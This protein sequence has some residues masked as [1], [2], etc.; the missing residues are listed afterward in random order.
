MTHDTQAIQRRQAHEATRNTPVADATT[1]VGGRLGTL[2]ETASQ[3][4]LAITYWFDPAPHTEPYPVTIRFVGRRVDVAGEAQAGDR[5]IHD[6]TVAA[7]VPGSGPVA[8]T[9][10]VFGVTPGR[11]QVTAQPQGSGRH[12][13]TRRERTPAV[14]SSDSKS[15][16]YPWLPRLWRHWAPSTG[17]S[18]DTAEPVETRLLPFIRMP[19]TLPMAWATLV[20]LGMAL[21]LVTQALLL[22]HSHRAPG[23]ALAASLVALVIGIVGAKLWYIVKHWRARRMDGW[24]IQGFIVGASLATLLLLALLRQPIGIVLDATA[25]GLLFGL[26]VGRLGCFLAGCCGGPPTASRWGVWSSDQRIGARRIPT[27][28]MESA[29][30][31]SV[32]VLALAVVLL[33]GPSNGTIFVG[34]LAA[35]TLGRQGIMRLRAEPSMS[36][37]GIP[38]TAA[39]TAV[40]LVAAIIIHVR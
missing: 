18:L 11:W 25:P 21:A 17:Q 6:E 30:T 13:S 16:D 37:L 4:V 19:G 12:I 9:A 34:A 1:S 33:H 22:A 40:T 38:A 15:G 27:Q 31:L 2:M 35:Y 28:L 29:L 36:R 7:V 8:V 32:G 14:A 23:Q 10:R 39:V 20:G 5:F 24:C 3:E 26:A